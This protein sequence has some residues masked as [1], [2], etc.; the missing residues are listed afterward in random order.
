MNVWYF[1]LPLRLCKTTV[2]KKKEKCLCA[3]EK[4]AEQKPRGL[5][6]VKNKSEVEDSLSPAGGKSK[7]CV[8]LPA[9]VTMTLGAASCHPLSEYGILSSPRCSVGL[10]YSVSEG[11]I[12]CNKKKNEGKGEC[13]PGWGIFPLDSWLLYGG[14]DL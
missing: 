6:H 1:L 13:K 12:V 7:S 14:C 2:K 3:H 11:L 5:N 4:D 8:K 9:G 10:L